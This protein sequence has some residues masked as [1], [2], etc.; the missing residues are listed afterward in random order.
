MVQVELRYDYVGDVT[1]RSI[2]SFFS[3]G[4]SQA[5]IDT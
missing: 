5:L 3:K 4:N 2:E 1:Y